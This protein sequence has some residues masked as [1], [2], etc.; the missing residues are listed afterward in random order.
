MVIHFVNLLSV[1]SRRTGKS[2]GVTSLRHTLR[3]KSCS[4]SLSFSF[5]KLQVS[6]NVSLVLLKILLADFR[7][8][9][10]VGAEEE[11]GANERLRDDAF[12]HRHRA[13]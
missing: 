10:L 7:T 1:V 11:L 2:R 3:Q 5:E 12:D 4:K 6:D 8:V 9:R 13:E